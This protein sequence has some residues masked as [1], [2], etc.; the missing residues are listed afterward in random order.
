MKKTIKLLLQVLPVLMIFCISC[1]KNEMEDET[2]DNC[3]ST[4]PEI[5]A[6]YKAIQ[7]FTQFINKMGEDLQTRSTITSPVIK[8]VKKTTSSVYGYTNN[9]STLKNSTA[10]NELPI[11]ELTLE[12][13][14]NTLGYAVV[15]LDQTIDQVVAYAPYG[16][17][18]DTIY[19]KAL[20]LQFREL[21]YLSTAISEQ[22]STYSE[23]WQPGWDNIFSLQVSGEE[24]VRWLTE[25]EIENY[26]KPYS[27]IF[28]DPIDKM[29]IISA[30]VPTKWDQG[31]PY[32]N[33]VPVFTTANPNERVQIGCYPVAVGQVMA[34]HKKP[35]KYNW[36]L[37]TAS[38]KI[39][40]TNYQA[41]QEVSRL[42]YDIAKAAS[43]KFDPIKNSGSTP[44][45][46][47]QIGLSSLGYTSNYTFLDNG[48][49][50]TLIRDEI[51][52]NNRPVLFSAQS[53]KGGHIWVIDAVLVQER[54]KYQ[55]AV[56]VGGDDHLKHS[57]NRYRMQGNLLHCNWGWA[58]KSD[59]W[60]FSYQ[61]IHDKLGTINFNS[62]KRLYTNIKPI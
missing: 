59:G 62:Y 45:L 57:L 32:N 48:K 6:E 26:T 10:Q 51:K 39:L 20:A 36:D 9:S 47:D 4:N 44:V 27:W 53:D 11:Y 12:N 60:Y 24:F 15:A 2:G 5:S 38:D 41:S 3:I 46:N 1:S 19:N 22:A 37:I 31:K 34:F 52:N 33:L 25:W 29:E 56:I 61:P 40:F 8:S 16:S 14:D 43:T 23:Y 35:T 58:G 21:A 42:L 49:S 13:P 17:I 54:W 30:Y 18:S 28:Y 55:S 50:A 7:T